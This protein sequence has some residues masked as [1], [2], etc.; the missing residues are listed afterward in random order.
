MNPARKT[1]ELP[2]SAQPDATGL[3]MDAVMA[4]SLSMRARETLVR[5]PVNGP[6]VSFEEIDKQI[7]RLAT[8][9]V[10]LGCEPGATAVIAA[11]LGRESFVSIMAARRVGLMPCVVPADMDAAVLSQ[12][13]TR[14]E[15]PVALGMDCVGHIRPL[16]EMREAAAS[17]FHL[18]LLAGFGAQVPPGVASLDAIIADEPS[19]S[20]LPCAYPP[21]TGF[22]VLQDAG[23]EPSVITED[24]IMAGALEIAR[25]ITPVPGSRIITTMTGVDLATVA[26]SFGTALLAGMEVTPLGLFSLARLW[27]SLS[28]GAQLHIVAPGALEEAFVQT[29][30]AEH[31]SVASLVFVHEPGVEMPPRERPAKGCMVIDV[32]RPSAASMRTARR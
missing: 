23:S 32:T 24:D 27:A 4:S 8:F 15:A 9:L 10:S 11:P 6:A 29:G 12:V 22:R 5:S 21:I 31:R 17:S 3:T 2:V 19:V 7:V 1:P 14:H 20:S 16:L 28:D 18:R 26:T 25:C 13:I 30:L